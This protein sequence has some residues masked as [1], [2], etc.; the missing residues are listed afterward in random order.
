MAKALSRFFGQFRWHSCVLC[1]LADLATPLHAA[2]HTI[3]FWWMD[4]EDEAYHSLKVMLSHAPVVQ[5]PKWW[6]PFHM[7]MDASN[8]A[9]GSALMQKTPPNW[10]RPVYYTSGR[11]SIAEKNYSTTEREALRMKYNITKFCHYLLGWK[12]PFHVDHSTLLYLVNKQD[13]TS[14]FARWMLLLQEFNFYQGS[15]MQ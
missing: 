8:I 3:P 4:Q 2:M 12:F 15:N 9:I 6:Q 13:L 5:P 7:F 14:R 10:Y 1:Y 11:L